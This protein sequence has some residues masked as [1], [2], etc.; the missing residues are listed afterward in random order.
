[1]NHWYRLRRIRFAV[2]LILIGVLALLNQWRIMSWHKSWPFFLIVPGLLAL[3]ERA[4]WTVDA[5]A[6]QAAQEAGVF[7][8]PGT[9]TIAPGPMPINPAEPSSWSAP[10]PSGAA[11]KSF[12]QPY[13]PAPEDPDREDR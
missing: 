10:P 1:M 4:A 6:Q 2:F 3:A 11:E 9:G 13:P 7:T 12:V 5:R 8:G